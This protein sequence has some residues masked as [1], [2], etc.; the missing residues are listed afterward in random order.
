MLIIA[1]LL[2]LSG[3]LTCHASV[4]PEVVAL[5][6][7][8]NSAG[9]NQSAVQSDRQEEHGISRK[10]EEVIRLFGF[11]ITNSMIV[12]WAV[13]RADCL[14]AYRYPQ[15][16]IGADGHAKFMGMDGWRLAEFS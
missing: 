1:G 10:P 5:A 3:G 14:G 11:P 8:T 7:A 2:S 6:V 9:P 12:T 15:H 4:R 13:A 16:E